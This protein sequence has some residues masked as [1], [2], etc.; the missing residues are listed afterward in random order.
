MP[1]P[2]RVNRAIIIDS[3]LRQVRLY[4]NTGLKSLQAAVGGHI[5]TAHIL[6][7]GDTL[8]V[9]DDG[10]LKYYDTGFS[11]SGAHQLFVGNGVIVGP[12]D[13]HGDDTHAKSGIAEVEESVMFFRCDPRHK[14]GNEDEEHA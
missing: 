3:K 12:P 4:D 5:V 14:P 11:Y 13:E 2:K 8:F 9:D 6:P 7:N 1:R 10:L